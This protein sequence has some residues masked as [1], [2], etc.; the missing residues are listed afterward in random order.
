MV[1][2]RSSTES[3]LSP[4]KLRPEWLP[5]VRRES[6]EVDRPGPSMQL[7]QSKS[8]SRRVK[9]ACKNSC[10][11]GCELSF[12][13]SSFSSSSISA[14]TSIL[15]AVSSLLEHTVMTAW[16][17]RSIMMGMSW[18]DTP[19]QAR[20]TVDRSAGMWSVSCLSQRN[21]QRRKDNACVPMMGDAMAPDWK[22]CCSWYLVLRYGRRTGCSASPA[23]LNSVQPPVLSAGPPKCLRSSCMPNVVASSTSRSEH[24]LRSLA[25][26]LSA[27]TA[28]SSSLWHSWSAACAL[29]M[30]PLKISTFSSL[31]G[32]TAPTTPRHSPQRNWTR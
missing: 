28:S 30:I 9:T 2:R 29:E 24:P 26:I 32:S 20:N 8:L 18:R 19:E 3:L 16:G 12:P 5:P 13:K 10:Q 14:V 1:L 21:S 7:I 11:S 22:D 25:S 23:A 6:L 15:A 27:S 17:R 4:H 31:A